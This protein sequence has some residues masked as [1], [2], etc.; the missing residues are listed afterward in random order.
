MRHSFGARDG[1]TCGRPRRLSSPIAASLGA[2]VV[3]GAGRYKP[4]VASLQPARGLCM[5]SCITDEV[6]SNVFRDGT[7]AVHKFED[8]ARVDFSYDGILGAVK[9]TSNAR[10]VE[11]VDALQN[12]RT[13][14]PAQFYCAVNGQTY[15]GAL[16]RH[17]VAQSA[18]ARWDGSVGLLGLDIVLPFSQTAVPRLEIVTGERGRQDIFVHVDMSNLHL[19]VGQDVA[20][21]ILE[22]LHVDT[23]SASSAAPSAGSASARRVVDRP[24][25]R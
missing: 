24:K 12:R 3:A 9:T 5:S 13:L 14:S 6:A 10:G 17:D 19:L 2:L 25:R 1:T 7:K 15:R 20:Q 21:R 22:C 18:V 23:Q 4:W 8:A 11:A 16:A